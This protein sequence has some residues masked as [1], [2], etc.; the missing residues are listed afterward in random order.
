MTRLLLEV[1][2]A[3]GEHLSPG[4]QTGLALAVVALVAIAGRLFIL[5]IFRVAESDIVLLL[6]DAWTCALAANYAFTPYHTL[7]QR[8][9][10]PCVPHRH[11]KVWS[12][13]N[14]VTVA[15]SLARAFWSS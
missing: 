5:G 6:L 10:D 9:Q 15:V 4:V 2:E 14:Y 1:N 7:C 13:I 11:Y 3:S 8:H 12:L